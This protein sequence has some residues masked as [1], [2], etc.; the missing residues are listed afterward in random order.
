LANA[1][2]APRA[3]AAAAAAPV[4]SGADAYDGAGGSWKGFAGAVA[5]LAASIVAFVTLRHPAPPA[6]AGIFAVA[7]ESAPA[8]TPAPRVT[9]K[10]ADA[11][12]RGLSLLTDGNV[13]EALPL[14]AEAAQ[15]DSQ[16]ALYRHTYGRA[17]WLGN[18]KDAALGELAAATS[19]NP[20]SPVYWTELAR[21]QKDL[22][23]NSD[24]LRSFE[25]ATSLFPDSV[26][27]LKDYGTLLA[28]L[29]DRQRATAILKQ[30]ADKRPGDAQLQQEMAYALE[31]AGD[32]EN[33][34][35]LYRRVIAAVPE[36]P[37]ARSHLAEL[38]VQQNRSTEAVAVLKEGLAKEPERAPLLYRSLGSVLERTGSIAEAV[39]AYRQYVERAGDSTDAKEIEQR[40]AALERQLAARS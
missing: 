1:A 6:D 17:L 19:L 2:E 26:D 31:T 36:A 34:A 21:A 16:N 15:Q 13:A 28:R 38:L 30:V 23:R 27:I 22:G 3:E 40:A 24:A 29:D 25:H 12:A 39:A 11:F 35:T 7:N 5:L 37:I 20:D 10:G 32:V 33:A 4:A 9:K 8:P 18:Q 14:L